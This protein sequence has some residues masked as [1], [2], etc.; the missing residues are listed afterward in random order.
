VP[1]ANHPGTQ[2]GDVNELAGLQ[3]ILWPVH[4]VQNT[5]GAAFHP[6]LDLAAIAR[7]FRKGTDPT[8]DSYSAFFDNAHR[9]ST[10]LGEYLK[11]QGVSDVCLCGLATDYCVKS[12]AL[13]AV[14]LGFRVY[15]IEDASRG[16]NLHPGDLEK[17]IA[18]MRSK[19]VRVLKSTPPAR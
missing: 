3:Q 18:E 19:G 6:G 2:P 15:L 8:V 4:C 11:E 12:S 5:P 17:A 14:G 13:D 10:G 1:A 7:V 9:R 16:V